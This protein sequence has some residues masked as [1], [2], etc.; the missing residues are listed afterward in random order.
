MLLFRKITF[1]ILFLI[2]A[3]DFSPLYTNTNF[4]SL[5]GKIDLQEP[6]SQNEFVFYS[7]LKN[8]FSESNSKYIL[9]YAITTSKN[10]SA[11]SFDGTVHRIEISSSV[12][13]SLKEKTSGLEILSDKEEMSLSY[14]TFGSTA[15]VLNAERTTNKQLV[16]LL[17]DKV[18]DRISLTIVEKGS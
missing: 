17:A 1:A 11:L 13:F 10:D 2:S 5:I 9:N 16:V 7:Q 15:A 3:C 6:N 18:A 12:T 8:R 4:D 14:S